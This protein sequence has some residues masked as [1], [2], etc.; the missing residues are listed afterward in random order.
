MGSLTDEEDV[1]DPCDAASIRPADREWREALSKMSDRGGVAS[2]KLQAADTSRHKSKQGPE[3]DVTLQSRTE[4]TK[5]D[6]YGGTSGTAA[7]DK[8]KRWLGADSELQPRAKRTRLNTHASTPAAATPGNQRKRGPG[9]DI[10]LI[11]G[12]QV[13]A[14][15]TRISARSPSP[16]I[17]A[18]SC[19][20]K[21]VATDGEKRESLFASSRVT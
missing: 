2:G 20:K 9:A 4:R 7:G 10:D 6:M 15:N 21:R 5:A 3:E 16:P 14:K 11:S 8:R 17:V 12:S 1:G 13:V 19:S 18:K